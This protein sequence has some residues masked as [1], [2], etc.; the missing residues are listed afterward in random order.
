MVAMRACAEFAVMGDD[1]ERSAGMV[2]ALQQ[3]Q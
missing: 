1:D 3:G 2:Q